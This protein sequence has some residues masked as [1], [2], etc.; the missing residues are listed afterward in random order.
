MHLIPDFFSLHTR[1]P[2]QCPILVHRPCTE[3]LTGAPQPQCEHVGAQL[4]SAGLLECLPHCCCRTL[5]QQARG[6]WI[7]GTTWLHTHTQR[8]RRLVSG[9]SAAR[10]QLP[11][12]VK[13]SKAIDPE[14]GHVPS[15]R[16]GQQARTQVDETRGARG[17]GEAEAEAEAEALSASEI[18][19]EGHVAESSY[20]PATAPCSSLL[21]PRR[22]PLLFANSPIPQFFLV[23]SS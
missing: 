11:G 23:S 10:C 13:P 6:H 8:R 18:R 5:H 16:A 19:E 4:I 22:P 21:H 3:G 14:L 15:C 9:C 2:S 17:E 7:G 1:K 20:P 12:F